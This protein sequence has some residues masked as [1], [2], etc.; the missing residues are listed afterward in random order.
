MTHD[1]VAITGIGMVTPGG[2]GTQA[3]WAAVR[4]ARP[5]AAED[6]EL[7]G[8]PVTFASRVPRFDSRALLGARTSARLDRVGQ[9][10]LVAAEEAVIAAG[11]D[12][13][14]WND[15]R[16]AV[17]IGT[18]AGGV[19]TY[20]RQVRRLIE[21]GPDRVSAFTLPMAL[22]NMVAAEI[23]MR[24]GAKGPNLVVAT[25]C[26][27]GATAVGTARALLHANACDVVLAGGSEAAVTPLF[28]AA[29]ARMGALSRR[30]DDPTGASRPFDTR[31]DG[32]VMGEGAGV[33]VVERLADARARR[34]PVLATVL[35]YGASDDA[36]HPTLPPTDGSGARRAIEAAC[37]DAALAPTE[38]DHVNAHATSTP[39][40][41]AAEAAALR[42][43]VGPDCPITA[44][45]GVTGHTL[46][47]AGAIE[48]GCTVL[49]LTA[50]IIPPVANVDAVDPALGIRVV[51]GQP[52][53]GDFSTALSTSFGF[54]GQNAALLLA[55]A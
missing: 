27:S 13:A 37:A 48:V 51:T 29:F 17:V 20:E 31:R 3:S 39:A 7:A 33:V 32:F 6:P 18:G 34:V 12:T 15:T 25:A 2:V 42:A 21:A 26:A 35:G 43:T 14:S 50:G 5:T 16:V 40:G 11:L 8:L 36:H 4:Q 49:S 19:G 22:P 47:A 45:K 46:G 23:A 10:A 24:L 41:D 38:I 53:T 30:N 52:L 44:N 54:G 28:V 1:P 55:R 9:F